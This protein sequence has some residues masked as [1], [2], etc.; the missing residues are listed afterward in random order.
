MKVYHKSTILDLDEL[1]RFK[2]GRDIREKPGKIRFFFRSPKILL[3]FDQ[4]F[5]WPALNY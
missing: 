1:N 2:N 3:V 5:N 4:K